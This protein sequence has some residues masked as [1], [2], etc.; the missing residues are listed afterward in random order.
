MLREEEVREG[1]EE[2]L[3][4]EECDLAVAPVNRVRSKCVGGMCFVSI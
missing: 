1:D 4:R 2:V 3:R